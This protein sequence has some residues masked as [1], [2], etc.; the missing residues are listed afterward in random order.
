MREILPTIVPVNR[1][2]TVAAND[3]PR[4]SETECSGAPASLNMSASG[5]RSF[6]LRDNWS[7]HQTKT[8]CVF[9]AST[10]AGSYR[11][12]GR[13]GPGRARYLPKRP[14]PVR[15]LTSPRSCSVA[16][17]PSWSKFVNGLMSPMTVTAH[18]KHLP[19]IA[20]H[21]R[22]FTQA[23][24][25]FRKRFRAKDSLSLRLNGQSRSCLCVAGRF[26]FPREQSPPPNS[27]AR[28]GRSRTP[29][30]REPP[31]IVRTA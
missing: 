15:T 12:P 29:R 8:R 26:T 20:R 1:P 6:T 16:Y 13:A 5:I 22:N 9:P 24:R 25:G 23:T 21:C 11:R 10:A 14:R 19:T 17:P 18:G 2:S 31:A 4:F 28:S 7:S 30:H 27:I 3:K